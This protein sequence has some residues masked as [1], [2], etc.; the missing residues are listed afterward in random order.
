MMPYT[1]V[2]RRIVIGHRTDHV[3][4]NVWYKLVMVAVTT[5]LGLPFYGV[6]DPSINVLQE[7]L[8]LGHI[9]SSERA[10]EKAITLYGSD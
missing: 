7:S 5:P 4:R 10:A 3:Q 1:Y 8:C 2:V 9:A 6:P